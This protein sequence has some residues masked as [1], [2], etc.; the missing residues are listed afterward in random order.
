M[1]LIDAN[2]LIYAY[3]SSSLFHPKAKDWLEEMLSRPEP[4]RLAW[5]SIL[6][7]L[8]ITT[9]QR[10]F[11]QPF[12]LEEA[13]EIVDSWLAQPQ[14]EILTPGPRHWSILRELLTN[15]QARGP[16]VMDTHLAALAVEYG[17]SLCST[18][19][20]FARF[21]RLRWENPLEKPQPGW[22]HETR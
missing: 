17:A 19:R 22:V 7:F 12:S 4:V 11:A 13:Q 20:D 5:S 6:A 14:V 2:L 10:I 15:A 18:D 16:L 9:H 1:I 3:E 8:R 21:E